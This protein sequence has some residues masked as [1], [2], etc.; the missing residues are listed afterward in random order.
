M[1][2]TQIA[3]PIATACRPW[4]ASEYTCLGR[5]TDG[6]ECQVP[7]TLCS[8]AG[9]VLKPFYT[10]ISPH[11]ERG[12]DEGA[13]TAGPE[14]EVAVRAVQDGLSHPVSQWLR[15][16]QLT[17]DLDE[18]HLARWPPAQWQAWADLH[19]TLPMIRRGEVDVVAGVPTLALLPGYQPPSDLTVPFPY[20]GRLHTTVT[21]MLRTVT[22]SRGLVR[23]SSRLFGGPSVRTLFEVAERCQGSSCQQSLAAVLLPQENGKGLIAEITYICAQAEHPTIGKQ[24][25]LTDLFDSRRACT[26]QAGAG[27]W[28]WA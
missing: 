3:S 18:N 26:C 15:V 4:C 9:G 1:S 20:V 19:N 2:Q 16:V 23:V 24:P 12:C 5:T 7:M 10:T 13:W 28:R 21:G 22:Q 11:H 17:C 8:P 25:D 27:Q 6:E 14:A